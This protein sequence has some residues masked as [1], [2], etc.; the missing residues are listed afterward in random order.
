MWVGFS[1]Q[2]YGGLSLPFNLA[3]LEAPACDVLISPDL[4]YAIPNVLGTSVWTLAIPSVPGWTFYN[5]AIA[6]DASANNLG[7]VFSN[8]GEAVVGQ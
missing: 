7:L 2:S 1:N 8:A 5:Q 3:A 4:L 6:F